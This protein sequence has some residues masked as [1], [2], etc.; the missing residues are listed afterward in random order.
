MCA[1]VNVHYTY[2]GTQ[3]G[4]TVESPGTKGEREPLAIGAGN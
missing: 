3:R 4:Q 1:Y 2:M